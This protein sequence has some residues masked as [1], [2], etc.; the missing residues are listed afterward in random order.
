MGQMLFLYILHILVD[1]FFDSLWE[2]SG[3]KVF[4]MEKILI[5]GA[6]CLLRHCWLFLDLVL[7]NYMCL[8][9]LFHVI[10][11]ISIKLFMIFYYFWKISDVST[12]NQTLFIYISFLF[13]LIHLFR[14]LS[15]SIT[16]VC[17]CWSLHSISTASLIISSFLPSL[18]LFWFLPSN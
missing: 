6:M 5:T 8:Q 9:I 13:F 11:L 15:F 1:L 16:N 18:R 17:L 7:L 14:S 2:P 10:K 12:Y 4:L 3:V